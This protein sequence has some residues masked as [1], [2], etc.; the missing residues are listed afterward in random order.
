[1]VCVT[2]LRVFASYIP[3]S[4]L[5]KK[6]RKLGGFDGRATQPVSLSVE[7]GLSSQAELVPELSDSR[8]ARLCVLD[9]ALN[10]HV[11]ARRELS[12][13][14]NSRPAARAACWN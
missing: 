3:T 14:C 1:M 8:T 5:V 13:Y 9:P 6:K 10:K 4:A 12:I 11:P 7:R 2:G